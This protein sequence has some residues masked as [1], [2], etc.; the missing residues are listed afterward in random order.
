GHHVPRRPV[1]GAGEFEPPRSAQLAR[2][3]GRGRYPGGRREAARGGAAGDQAGAQGAARPRPDP[4]GV[5]DRGREDRHDGPRARRIYDQPGGRTLPGE[6]ARRAGSQRRPARRPADP[7][8]DRA[9]CRRR[10]RQSGAATPVAAPS[11]AQ[12]PARVE[13]QSVLAV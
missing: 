4:Q 3:D 13:R 12:R 11:G 10:P 2:D 8:G 6:R 1:G 5:A 9:V 7:P